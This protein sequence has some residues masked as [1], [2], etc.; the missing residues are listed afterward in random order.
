MFA[1]MDKAERAGTGFK[2]IKDI[3]DK[4]KFPFPQIEND[5]FCRVTFKRPAKSRGSKKTVEKILGLIR[6][7]NEITQEELA[8][9]TGLLRRGIEWNIQQLKAKKILKRV[10]PDKGGYWKV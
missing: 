2:R 3:L 9:K 7:N 5:T 10:G 1:R 8:E 4:E 6:E